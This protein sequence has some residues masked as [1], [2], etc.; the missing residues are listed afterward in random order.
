MFRRSPIT[1]RATEGSEAVTKDASVDN[2]IQPT[3]RA[4]ANSS[5]VIPKNASKSTRLSRSLPNFV[6]VKG[7]MKYVTEDE[8]VHSKYGSESKEGNETVH[9][10]RVVL[11]NIEIREYDRTVGDN[12][13]C[14]SGPP[15]S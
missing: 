10:K 2:A 5:E 15:I 8:S 3:R 4:R 13:S 6:R 11:K 1:R 9:S 7:I 12:P 14:S